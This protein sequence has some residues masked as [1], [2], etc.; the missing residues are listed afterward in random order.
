MR[1]GHDSGGLVVARDEDEL[2]KQVQS[3]DADAFEELYVRYAARA[4]RV[5]KSVCRDDGRAQDAVQ[6]A[7]LSIWRSRATYRP[8]RGTVPIWLLS[9]VRY[10]AIDATRRNEKHAANRAGEHLLEAHAAPAEVADQAVARA[11]APRL[12]AILRRLPDAQREV[13]ALA[14][15]G[16]LS[17]TEIATRLDLPPGT[18]KGRMRLGLEKV[19]ADIEQAA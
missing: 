8:Q 12:H 18:V 4:H 9:V 10:R 11:D 5:A 19:R 7:F 6:E 17:H 1:A 16:Q 15:Y 14:Y 3:G 13:I 2:M